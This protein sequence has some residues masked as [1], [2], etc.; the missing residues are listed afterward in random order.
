MI[1]CLLLIVVSGCSVFQPGRDRPKTALSKREF[2]DVYVALARAKDPATRQR[3]LQQHG[4][5]SR[6]LE[7]F[8]EAYT[9]HLPELSAVFDSIVARLG[10]EPGMEVPALPY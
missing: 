9:D 6:E 5:T 7:Q 10:M 2:V 3:I 4:T 8:V 1:F